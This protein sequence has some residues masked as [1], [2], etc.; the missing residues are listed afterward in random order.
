MSR[1]GPLVHPFAAI[2]EAGAYALFVTGGMV[3]L[4]WHGGVD[5]GISNKFALK[6]ERKL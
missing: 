2:T 6:K 4:L 3:S 5:L 1:I